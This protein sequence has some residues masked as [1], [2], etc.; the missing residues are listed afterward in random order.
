MIMIIDVRDFERDQA[1]LSE[2]SE[3]EPSTIGAQDRGRGWGEDE[4][5]LPTRHSRKRGVE[6]KVANQPDVGDDD[7]LGGKQR[8]AK[9]QK[10]NNVSDI[11]C[12]T[13]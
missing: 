11:H 12:L 4:E 13:S 8:T 5:G 7:G 10:T 3:A 6:A 2:L 1:G 9:K